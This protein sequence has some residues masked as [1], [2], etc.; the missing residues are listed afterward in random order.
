MLHEADAGI[1]Q[2]AS[3]VENRVAQLLQRYSLDKENITTP[4]PAPDQRHKH[5]QLRYR[6]RRRD[7]S[8]YNP[9][10]ARTHEDIPQPVNQATVTVPPTRLNIRC[11][12]ALY[13]CYG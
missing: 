10:Q 3:H 6:L 12:Y 13:S 11:E 5:D 1:N 7:R 9:Q 8:R 4:A 2:V